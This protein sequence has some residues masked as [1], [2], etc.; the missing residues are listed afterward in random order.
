MGLLL[1]S[2]P[3]IDFFPHSKTVSDTPPLLSY[4]FFLSGTFKVQVNKLIENIYVPTYPII[5]FNKFDAPK[6]IR[7]GRSRTF[8]HFE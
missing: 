8:Y 6:I 3:F 2:Y 7:Q 5:T 1:G 4:I